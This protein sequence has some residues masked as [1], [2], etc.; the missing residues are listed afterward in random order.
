MNR[1]AKCLPF[2]VP[3]TILNR[4]GCHRLIREGAKLVESTFDIFSELKHWLPKT[5]ASEP[6]PTA[7]T[8][9]QPVRKIVPA[10]TDPIERQ[11]FELLTE[12]LTIDDIVVRTQL[13]THIAT[14]AIMMME[15]EGTIVRQ[16]SQHFI[17]GTV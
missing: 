17:Q 14:Q 3:F 12:P 15:L 8:P 6:Q 11:I 4:K 2:Q 10:P 9:L 13:D 7:L 1:A 5:N 16:D